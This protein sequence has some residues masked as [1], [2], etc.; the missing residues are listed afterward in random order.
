MPGLMIT[1]LMFIL[2]LLFSHFCFVKIPIGF[3]FLLATH[4]D[5]E[6]V[7][8][9]VV[10]LCMGIHGGCFVGLGVQNFMDVLL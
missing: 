8:L 9:I 7:R 4:G 10:R 3:E 2:K 1:S 6:G 5:R